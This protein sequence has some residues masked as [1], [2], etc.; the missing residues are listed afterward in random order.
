MP[1]FDD[2]EA[3][4]TDDYEW[5]RFRGPQPY[6]CPA[7][8]V[9]NDVEADGVGWY[10]YPGHAEGL[11][12]QYDIDELFGD[13]YEARQEARAEEGVLLN[14]FDFDGHRDDDPD[15]EHRLSIAGETVLQWVNPD[16]EDLWAAVA[17]ILAQY[18]GGRDLEEIDVTPASGHPPQEAREE[19]RVEQRREDNAQLEDFTD[20]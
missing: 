10:R 1:N 12:D 9:L 4:W 19:D 7:D 20:A 8:W 17:E 16:D 2:L 3:D 11:H 14:E 5:T 6:P 13:D 18:S 15:V